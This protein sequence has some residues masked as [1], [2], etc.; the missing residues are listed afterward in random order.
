MENV[1]R[2]LNEIFI[3]GAVSAYQDWY[4]HNDCK[5][6]PLKWNFLSSSSV[7]KE[8][9]I[10][11]NQEQAWKTTYCWAKKRYQDKVFLVIK[12]EEW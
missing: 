11:N 6:I 5:M 10:V 12:W 4:N 9:P 1:G 7:I 3:G 8:Q 2:S